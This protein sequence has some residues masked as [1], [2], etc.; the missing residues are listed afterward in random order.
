MKIREENPAREPKIVLA[1]EE[2]RHHALKTVEKVLKFHIEQRQ[3]PFLI[4]KEALECNSLWCKFQFHDRLTSDVLAPFASYFGTFSGNMSRTTRAKALA[5]YKRAM[6]SK[7]SKRDGYGASLMAAPALEDP[8]LRVTG[9]NTSQAKQFGDKS[10]CSLCTKWGHRDSDYSK[11]EW[12]E[13]EVKKIQENVAA[14]KD[15]N[16]VV[17]VGSST[18]E[19]VGV[20]IPEEI[21]SMEVVDAEKE[22]EKEAERAS[23]IISEEVAENAENTTIV[24]A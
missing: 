6:V 11:K 18:K 16:N 4:S 21:L 19:D 22:T 12:K 7:I 9:D 23:V 20:T 2:G 14:S 8:P 1:G 17:D 3:V 15:Q 24:E 5:E 13:P 10:Y